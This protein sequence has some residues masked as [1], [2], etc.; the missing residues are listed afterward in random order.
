M[1]Y[2]QENLENGKAA[3]TRLY[4]ALRGLSPEN[5][6]DPDCEGY[7]VAFN[8]A[9]NDDFN[10]P[11]AVA[12]L[13]ELAREINKNREAEPGKSNAL[14]GCLCRL[15]SVLGLLQTD[16]ET[17]LRESVVQEGAAP[18]LSEPD[19]ESLIA[20]RISARNEKNW[21]EA[22]RIRDDLEA[23][24]IVIEDGAS[25]TTWRRN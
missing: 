2:S 13:F 3:L 23:A 22:D 5:G 10:S 12:V 21:A 17:Y 19:I 8:N 7:V 25:G 16:P 24:G 11:E 9:M 15:G 20:S 14:A 1:N 4:T 6:I 18:G